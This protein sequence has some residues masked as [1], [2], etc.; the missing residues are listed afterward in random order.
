M[1]AS[2]VDVF[3]LLL[4]GNIAKIDSNFQLEDKEEA[5]DGEVSSLARAHRTKRCNF[6]PRIQSRNSLLSLST[7]HAHRQVNTPFFLVPLCTPLDARQ[8]LMRGGRRC[9]GASRPA[10]APFGPASP[11]LQQVVAVVVAAAMEVREEEEESVFGRGGGGSFI[12]LRHRT[13]FG[14]FS[15]GFG[16][17]G[18]GG[19]GGAFPSRLLLPVWWCRGERTPCGVRENDMKKIRRCSMVIITLTLTACAKNGNFNCF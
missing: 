1:V 5:P 2:D 18:G 7:I 13:V 3:L 14:V 15:E 9:G 8:Q 4:S 16:K 17:G 11:F 10:C 12:H 6:T 19:G